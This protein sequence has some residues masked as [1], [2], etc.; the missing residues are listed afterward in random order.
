MTIISAADLRV[1]QALA[2]VRQTAGWTREQLA[3]VIGLTAFDLAQAEAGR[4]R[5]Q[6]ADLFSVSAA[7][8]TPA[9]PLLA[10]ITAN[11]R[12]SV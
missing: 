8:R 12:V 10:M 3:P 2:G 11:D 9:A 7:M 6:T 1:G 4:R 5:L